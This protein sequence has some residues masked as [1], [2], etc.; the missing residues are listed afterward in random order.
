MGSS[1][2]T[3]DGQLRCNCHPGVSSTREKQLAGAH[4]LVLSRVFEGKQKTFLVV[5]FKGTFGFIPFLTYRSK[6]RPMLCAWIICRSAGSKKADAVFGIW[7]RFST[8]GGSSTSHFSIQWEDV[9]LDRA[10]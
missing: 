5:S 1:T 7:L 2:N 3:C 4:L 10:P 8:A 9:W 6:A